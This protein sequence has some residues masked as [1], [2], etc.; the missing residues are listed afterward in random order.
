[1]TRPTPK[2]R[3]RRYRVR[4]VTDWIVEA[5][6]PDEA[7]QRWRDDPDGFEDPHVRFDWCEVEAVSELPDPTEPQSV[8]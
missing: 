8:T 7:E 1:M 5:E 2:M 4:T 6:G 3:T